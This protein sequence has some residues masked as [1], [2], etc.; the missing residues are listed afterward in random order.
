MVGTQHPSFAAFTLAKSQQ[1]AY[2]PLKNLYAASL[3]R[4]ILVQ[5]VE[6]PDIFLPGR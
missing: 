1:I 4:G 5:V 2:R 6:L 3:L